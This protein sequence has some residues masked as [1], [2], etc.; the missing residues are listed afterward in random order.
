MC[1]SEVDLLEIIKIGS[2]RS[3][4]W[5]FSKRKTVRVSAEATFP[6][7]TPGGLAMKSN[8]AENKHGSER[9]RKA[10][11][12]VI[13]SKRCLHG[14]LNQDSQCALTDSTGLVSMDRTRCRKSS[15]CSCQRGTPGVSSYTCLQFFV[16]VSCVWCNSH[17]IHNS[18]PYQTPSPTSKEGSVFWDQWAGSR[19]VGLVGWA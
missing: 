19:R 10:K 18:I 5:A 7:W 16:P 3:R 11:F 1:R 17:V 4:T 14:Y 2:T 13:A 9:H 8:N 15:K 6:V 12:L